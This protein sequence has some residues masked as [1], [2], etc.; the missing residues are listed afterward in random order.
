M[1]QSLPAAVWIAV[2]SS[3]TTLAVF[4]LAVV[5]LIWHQRRSA[6]EA[7]QWGRRVLA[8]QDAERHRVAME[9]HDDIGQQLHAARFAVERG[10]G[11]TVAVELGR[12]IARLRDLAHDLYPPMLAARELTI[13]LSGLVRRQSG[14]GAPPIE[15]TVP[16]TVSLSDAAALALYRVAQ[17][18]LVNAVKHADAGAIRLALQEE[19]HEVV[20]I[21]A[22]DGIGLPDDLKART[23]F[24]L[25]SMRE[26]MEGVGGTLEVARGTPHGTRLIARVPRA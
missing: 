15:V 9:L 25:R 16:D 4:G 22:D 14:R 23:S 21:L 12:I 8:A 26:R 2:V 3:V 6:A 18:G 20:L 13:A 10:E 1:D 5:I 19:A 7:Q 11:A 17:E 24:G